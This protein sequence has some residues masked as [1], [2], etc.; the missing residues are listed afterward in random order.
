MMGMQNGVLIGSLEYK[1]EWGEEEKYLIGNE[2]IAMLE[3]MA[4]STNN[5]GGE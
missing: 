3:L 4:G 2:L 5:K 1:V